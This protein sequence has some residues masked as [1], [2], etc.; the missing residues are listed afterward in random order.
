M[1]EVDKPYVSRRTYVPG[2][3]MINYNKTYA[4]SFSRLS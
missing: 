3:F 2:Y 1:T 4:H